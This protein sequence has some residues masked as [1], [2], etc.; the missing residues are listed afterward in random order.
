LRLFVEALGAVV[1]PLL[2]GRCRIAVIGS[3]PEIPADCAAGYL[4]AVETVSVASP[5]HPLA[6]FDRPVT[7]EEAAKHIQLVLT[8]RSALR[9]GRDFGVQSSKSGGWRTWVRSMPFCARVSVGDICRSTWSKQISGTAA[10]CA[11]N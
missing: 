5:D 2:D 7:H 10:W 11:L 4:M 9:Q 3:L 1:P 8:D 6:R